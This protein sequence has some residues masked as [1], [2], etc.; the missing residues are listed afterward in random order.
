VTRLV[1]SPAREAIE[2]SQLTAFTRFVSAKTGRRFPDYASLHAWSV[3]EF[4]TFWAIFLEW[5]RLE[6]TGSAEPVCTAGGISEASF[7]PGLHLNVT[8]QLLAGSGARGSDAAIVALTEAGSR[9]VVSWEELRQRVART[10]AALAQLGIAP[11]DRVAAIARNTADTIVGCLAA[12]GIGAT[13]CSVAPELGAAAV[14]A[15]FAPLAPKL[16]FADGSSVVQGRELPL[17]GTIRAVVE[18]TPSIERVVTFS[19]VEGVPRVPAVPLED[20]ARSEPPIREW[21]VLP[22]NHP[23]YVLFSSGTTGAPKCITH[24]AGGTLLEHLKEHRLHGDLSRSDVLYFHTS[25]GWM[26]WNW[27]LSALATGCRLVLYDGSPTFPSNDRLWHVVS[28][29][30]VTVLGTS[31]TYLQFCEDAALVPR[32]I[33]DLSRLR[34]IQSTGSILRE[35]QYDWVATHVKNVP[36]QSISGGTDILGCFVLGNPNLPVVAGESQ[37]IGLGLDVRALPTEAA[38]ALGPRVGELVCGTPF[39]SRPLGFFGDAAGLRFH[40]AYFAA[41]PGFWT[42]GD[43]IEITP[44]GGAKILGRSDGVLNVRGIRIG[45]AEVYRVLE[46]FEGVSDA[47]ALE[48]TDPT[49]PGGTRLVLLLVLRPGVTLDRPLSLAIKKALRDEASAAHVP[50]VIA[51]MSGFPTTFSGKISARA[52]QDTLEGREPPNR[53]ALRNPETLDELRDHPELAR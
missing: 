25:A 21:P 35:R 29:E 27:M 19:P 41:N 5:L 3:E 4:R 6:V 13:W 34:A 2:A 23:L 42:H 40:D 15:R 48:Q 28:A 20:L 44:R 49:S 17:G 33:A 22:F 47:L 39:P 24:G 53:A 52:A 36:L 26:M 9:T 10:A 1:F 45:P 18:A 31:P 46:R 30:G 12:T 8:S 7:F 38:S 43:F 14:I 51:A 11:G 50:A 37:C 32:E 16:L